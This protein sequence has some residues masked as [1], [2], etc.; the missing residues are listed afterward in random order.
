IELYTQFL[1]NKIDIYKEMLS[2]RDIK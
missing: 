2:A 1:L